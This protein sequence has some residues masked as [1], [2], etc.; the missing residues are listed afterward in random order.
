MRMALAMLRQAAAQ[1]ITHVACTPHL[2]DRAT[3][4]LDRRY[5]SVFLN[6][7]NE[8]SHSGLSISLQLG[9]E[10]MLGSELKGILSLQV[11]SFGGQQ[12]YILLE[13]PVSTPHEIALNAVKA[14]R[15][16]N[17]IPV[18]AHIER[19]TQA[20]R[21]LEQAKALRAAGAVLSLDGGSL[22]GQFGPTM[23]KRGETLVKEGFVD[24]MM[25]DAHNDTDQSF[26]QKRAYERAAELLGEASARKL[27]LD[28]P[29]RI[30][31]NQ[32]WPELR[33][34]KESL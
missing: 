11:A 3:P 25:S 19:F 29:Q 2:N 21:T 8:V 17:H 27:V 1:G 13:F 18:L 7:V 23:V 16:W 34:D 14:V 24:M 31:E 22:I 33:P 15:K 26:C 4:E 20:V 6:L 5:Q 10:I 12:R 32:P 28:N 9:S 30:W